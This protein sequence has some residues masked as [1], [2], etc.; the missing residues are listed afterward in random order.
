MENGRIIPRTIKA[1]SPCYELYKKLDP[2][3]WQINDEIECKLEDPKDYRKTVENILETLIRMD[4]EYEKE[5]LEYS[6]RFSLDPVEIYNI[7]RYEEIRPVLSYTVYAICDARTGGFYCCT[8]SFSG[9][10]RPLHSEYRSFLTE[11]FFGESSFYCFPFLLA[12]QRT[13]YFWL[14][15]VCRTFELKGSLGF[16]VRWA[17]SVENKT[18]YDLFSA[19]IHM[20][21][22]MTQSKMS[23]EGITTVAFNL[24]ISL[25]T[26][27][28][29]SNIL[30]IKFSDDFQFYSE[31]LNIRKNEVDKKISERF[32]SLVCTEKL[33]EDD[34]LI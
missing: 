5:Q 10:Y 20:E 34:S 29:R 24:K 27:F 2:E 33:P 28:R 4:S 14:L 13:C 21:F 17:H 26:Q 3:D 15:K 31:L 18:V 19:R 16:D 8:D 23:G 22:D 11:T 30:K 1:F 9:N 6:N 12:L 25:P 7:F 32:P